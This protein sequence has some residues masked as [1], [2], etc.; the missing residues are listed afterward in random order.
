MQTAP[1]RRIVPRFMVECDGIAWIIYDTV[2]RI[3]IPESRGELDSR[4]VVAEIMNGHWEAKCQKQS[5][6]VIPIR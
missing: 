6:K 1:Q 4:V 3:V 2:N 5:C